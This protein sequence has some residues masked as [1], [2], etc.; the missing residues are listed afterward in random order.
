[1]KKKLEKLGNTDDFTCPICSGQLIMY[2]EVLYEEY[3]D[4][5]LIEPTYMCQKCKRVYIK[6]DNKLHRIVLPEPLRNSDLRNSETK[7]YINSRVINWMDS[8]VV[9][10][11]Y[12]ETTDCK[13]NDDYITR[14]VNQAKQLAD[15]LHKL[16]DF[17]RTE[18][19][20]EL[21]REKKRYM[22]KQSNIMLQYL[23]VLGERLEL[24]NVDLTDYKFFDKSD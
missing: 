16:Q 17:M 10:R 22:Y 19:F 20:Y 15:K 2:D 21:P 8:D 3:N 18:K 1:M 6:K 9:Y 7:R 13:K 23:E 5:I 14:M 11:F 4:F 24:E 12:G